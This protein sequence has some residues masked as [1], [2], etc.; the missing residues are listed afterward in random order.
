M[1]LFS[2][3]DNNSPVMG[4]FERIGFHSR[5]I[6]YFHKC[7]ILKNTYKARRQEGVKGSKNDSHE[8]L[9]TRRHRRLF[10][11]IKLCSKTTIQTGCAMSST[12]IAKKKNWQRKNYLLIC[13][14]FLSVFLS[15]EHN[16]SFANTSRP[17]PTVRMDLQKLRIHKFHGFFE[18]K[19]HR[20][21]LRI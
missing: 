14:S 19:L 7:Y 6:K 9:V 8:N 16:V 10:K 11:M 2:S 18:T 17:P 20:T 21:K 4:H 12:G 13:Q 1:V 5:C 3:L 15:P